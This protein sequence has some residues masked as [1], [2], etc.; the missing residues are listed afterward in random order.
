[1]VGAAIVDSLRALHAAVDD[2]LKRAAHGD[3][4]ALSDEEFVEVAQDMDAIRRQLTTADYPVVAEVESRGLPDRSLTRNAAGYLGAVWRLTPHEAARR[5]REAEALGPRTAL[6]GEVLAPRYPLAAHARRVGV[7]GDAHTAVILKTLAELPTE[8]PVAEV[9]SAERILVQ[10][11]HALHAN[12]LANVARQLIDTINPD[13]TAPS[14]AEQQRRRHLSL[15]RDRDGMV[16]I[17]GVLDPVTG[18]KA[19]A[20]FG[21]MA[22][23]RPDDETGRDERTPGQRRHDALADLLGL[24]LRADDY[25]A[26]CGSPVTLQLTMTAD[27][28]AAGTGH[29]VTS[30]GQHIRI[31]SSLRVA[32][33]ACIAWAVHNGKGGILNF[34]RTRRLASRE[35]TEAL[36][37]RDAG[38]A[39]PGCDQPP[40][41]CERHHIREWRTGGCT[42]I[43]NLVLLCSY[44]HARFQ[45]QGWR[46]TI[47]DG[48]P[49][50]S[51]PPHIDPRRTPIRNQ[52][53]LAANLFDP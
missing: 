22:K 47:R 5:V 52:R 2:F 10:A 35:Q 27:Q 18:A 34:G 49:W 46:I 51:P 1:M 29:A 8:M 3:L 44:H 36:I 14:E 25:A 39:F 11:A 21:S 9:D 48:V 24:A 42:D 15:R 32:D 6:S 30:Y 19:Q 26:S 28:F 45:Q 40:Q 50:F 20:W 7:L 38:C 33:Q 13:G 23:P 4:G 17:G 31:A 41:W 53:G 16:R 12:D 43:D 37:A